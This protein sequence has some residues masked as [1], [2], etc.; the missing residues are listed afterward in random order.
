MRGPALQEFNENFRRPR[1]TAVAAISQPEFP[2]EFVVLQRDQ[3]HFTRLHLVA[4]KAFT[5]Q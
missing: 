5:D 4:G 1:Q 3:L 2:C